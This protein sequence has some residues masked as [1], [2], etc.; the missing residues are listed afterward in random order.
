M[1]SFLYVKKRCPECGLNKSKK[2][3]KRN[4]KQRY[5]CNVCRK[6]FQLENWKTQQ[7]ENL[8]DTYSSGK[9]TQ[10]QIADDIGKSRWWVNQKL[11]QNS[12]KTNDRNT[13]VTSQ[14]IVLII[15]TT[16]FE[17]FGLMVFRSANL[18]RNLLWYEVEN[19]TNDLYRKGIQE[20][21]NHGWI[22]QA[23]VADGKP[24]LRKLFPNIPFQLCQF[25]Q[26][27]I[28]T[29]YISKKPKLEAG[30]E[31]R[32]LMF[33]LKETDTAS[34]N[35]WIEKWYDKWKEFLSE[36]TINPIT[37]K[38]CF[39]HQRLRQAYSSLRRNKDSLFTFERC[40][41]NILVP[42]TTN[43]LDSYFGHLKAKLNV[44]RGASKETQL[45]IISSLIFL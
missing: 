24:G 37:D 4:G 28:I 34:F 13:S 26:F 31:L 30:K 41:P 2:I 33:L 17:Q 43:S 15:D 1:E 18:K 35:R 5:Q 14:R 42:N 32:K 10:Q 22:I 23:I 11:K 40:L 38:S 20:L 7:H 29:R 8:W 21:I 16:Y 19:E 12:H 45:K 27:Q 25:H 36:K 9:Q 44:H 3:G 6:K 39:T